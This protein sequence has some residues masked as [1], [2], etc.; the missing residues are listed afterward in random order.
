MANKNSLKDIQIRVRFTTE[1]Y[2]AY[3]KA[4]SASG[5]KSYSYNAEAL[6]AYISASSPVPA[7][8]RSSGFT[9]GEV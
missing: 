4:L 1:Q 3:K 9:G 7:D 6:M 5:R 2:K 8:G